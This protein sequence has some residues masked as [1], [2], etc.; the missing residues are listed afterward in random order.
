MNK[1]LRQGLVTL[2]L[3]AAI[4]GAC[5]AVSMAMNDVTIV[6]GC[7]GVCGGEVNIPSQADQ[8][9]VPHRPEIPT[10]EPPVIENPAPRQPDVQTPDRTP[11]AKIMLD[12]YCSQWKMSPVLRTNDAYGWRCA[13][14]G[15]ADINIS[16]TSL[17][18]QQL[19]TQWTDTYSSFNDPNSWSC[20]IA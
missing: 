15:A 12:R 2:G 14:S 18:E 3:L 1:R 6:T 11:V 10:D 16:M 13:R 19:G 20:Y 8:R 5:S 4:G 17:C 7:T 9:D